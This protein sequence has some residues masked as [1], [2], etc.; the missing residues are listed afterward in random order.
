MTGR[1]KGQANSSLWPTGKQGPILT[2][3][4]SLPSLSSRVPPPLQ[5]AKQSAFSLLLQRQFW[6]FLASRTCFPQNTVVVLWSKHMEANRPAW[7]NMGL[8]LTHKQGICMYLHTGGTWEWDRNGRDLEL[9]CSEKGAENS[10]LSCSFF[11]SIFF[12]FWPHSAVL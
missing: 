3:G 8:A 11:I 2:F 5:R 7:G 6:N 12:G 10:V 4:W 1:V 9:S